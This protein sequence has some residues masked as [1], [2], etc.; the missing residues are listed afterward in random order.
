MYAVKAVYD[1]A[2]FKPKQPIAIK[3]EYEVIITFV[4]PV[5]KSNTTNLPFKRGCMK[6][7]MWVA[8]DFNAPLEDFEEYMQ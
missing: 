4:E 5:K 1:G 2:N 6:E 3:E 7:K 8:D